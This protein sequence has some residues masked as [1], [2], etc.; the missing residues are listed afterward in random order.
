VVEVAS[1]LRVFS[2]FLSIFMTIINR[3]GFLITLIS[4][5]VGKG[6]VPGNCKVE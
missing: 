5:F 6:A 3:I 4:S 1:S 2:F